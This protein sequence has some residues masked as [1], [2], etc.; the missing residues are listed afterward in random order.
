MKKILNFLTPSRA[1]FICFVAF[2]ACVPSFIYCRNHHFCI[3]GHLQHEIT[4][5]EK[6]NDL[7]WHSG[8]LV[9]MVLGFR[10][11]II[12]RYAFIFAM[13]VGFLL[14]ADPRNLGGILILPVTAA[15]GL[16]AVAGLLGWLD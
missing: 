16:F 7:L 2:L 6:A 3:Y 8:F 14:I 12:F 15:A 13:A 4:F 5:W 9:G 11:E 1:T 10:S